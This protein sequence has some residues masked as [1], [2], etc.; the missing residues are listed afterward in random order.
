MPFFDDEQPRSPPPRLIDISGTFEEP[1]VANHN[2]SILPEPPFSPFSSLNPTSGSKPPLPIPQNTTNLLDTSMP[3]LISFEP[4]LPSTPPRPGSSSTNDTEDRDAL[5]VVDLLTPEG[6][7]SSIYEHPQL[8]LLG[9][10]PVRR[11]TRLSTLNR[12]SRTLSPALSNSSVQPGSRLSEPEEG[13]DEIAMLSNSMPLDYVEQLGSKP[14]GNS[15]ET[16]PVP[17]VTIS[18]PSSHLCSSMPA[19]PSSTGPSTQPR[20]SP[21]LSFDNAATT[22]PLPSPPTDPKHSPSN[23]DTHHGPPSSNKAQD[24][25][26]KRTATSKRRELG[27]LSPTSADVLS[28][29]LATGFEPRPESDRHS[30]SPAPPIFTDNIVTPSTPQRRPSPESANRESRFM[31][32]D[33]QRPP[34]GTPFRSPSKRHPSYPVKSSGTLNDPDRS[35]RRIPIAQAIAEGSL[36]MDKLPRY[37]S[38]NGL[39]AV[40]QSGT[41]LFGRPVFTR[42]DP[43]DPLRSP[44]RVPVSDKAAAPFPIRS[45]STSPNRTSRAGSAEPQ[46]LRKGLPTFKSSSK[47]LS[48]SELPS[49]AK[50]RSALP[51]PIRGATQRPGSKFI[52]AIPEEVEGQI[53]LPH[54]P[55]ANAG[56]ATGEAAS[57]SKSSLRQP[58][59][60]SRIP[61]IGA[62]PY[63]RPTESKLV[64]AARKASA[65]AA[66][67]SSF[68]ILW[69]RRS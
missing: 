39:G 59:N 46:P 68:T 37:P 40:S 63:A 28:N 53:P 38:S 56:P 69:I 24:V 29:I 34:S 43:N 44:R 20:R 6:P 17:L 48:D 9:P 23:I 15:P 66:P 30:P 49:T 3:D 26:G 55:A 25:K 33:V 10:S 54:V 12:N 47:A 22:T 19:S 8:D 32:S 65:N 16:T 4:L 18:S 5:L 36:T 50:S 41:G 58:S 27:S 62:K 31:I 7:T 2:Q 21:R 11:S 52:D 45:G 35:P 64:L 57:P 42:P 61:R 13:G 51:F 60:N 14:A 1:S 67:V